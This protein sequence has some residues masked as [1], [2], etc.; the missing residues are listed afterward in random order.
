M[1]P[2]PASRGEVLL[3]LRG[4][5]LSLV[6]PGT[7]AHGVSHCAETTSQGSVDAVHEIE[8]LVAEV[9]SYH[10]APGAR[11]TVVPDG[12]MDLVFRDGADADLFWVGPMTR[13]ESVSV[14]ELTHFVGVRFRPGVAP[15]LLGRDA[16]DLLDHDVPARDGRLLDALVAARTDEERRGLL[17]GALGQQRRAMPDPVVLSAATA[18]LESGGALRVSDL[19]VGVGLSERTL[20]R[21]FAASVGYGPKQLCRIARLGVARTLGK[22][23]FAGAQLAVQ[24][25]YFDQA[26]LCHDLASFGLTVESLLT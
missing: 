5:I 11:H 15:P 17:L 3:A 26:H 20:H 10:L 19:A 18:I 4:E 7:H 1:A 24:A 9:W 21:R 25:G 16:R 13:A 6:L 22:R 8:P 23:G 2:P 12:C 14:D